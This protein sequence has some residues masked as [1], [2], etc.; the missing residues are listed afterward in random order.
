MRDDAMTPM[1][2]AHEQAGP[3]TVGEAFDER[4]KYL[5]GELERVCILKAKAEALQILNF[6]KEFLYQVAWL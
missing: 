2:A 5:R 3:K 6:D 4:I 1:P